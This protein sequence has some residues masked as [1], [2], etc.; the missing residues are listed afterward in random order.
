[1]RKALYL[2]NPKGPDHGLPQTGPRVL[3]INLVAWPEI[4][5]VKSHD[6]GLVTNPSGC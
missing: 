5:P 2:H 1:M 3:R 4:G 6:Q